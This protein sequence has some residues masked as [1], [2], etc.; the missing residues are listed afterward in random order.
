MEQ[1]VHRGKACAQQ[2]NI[3][4]P[5][6]LRA[7][8][9]KMLPR[10]GLNRHLRQQQPDVD[11]FDDRCIV[12]LKY[13]RFRNCHQGRGRWQPQT[14]HQI[15]DGTANGNIGLRVSQ[16]DDGLLKLLALRIVHWL[17]KCRQRQHHDN[18]RQQ[19]RF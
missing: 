7:H 18:G 4:V 15:A 2:D 6:T 19:C 16:T 13:N 12:C 14:A 1:I 8:Q 10:A 5:R 11:Q 17:R 3:V 9:R